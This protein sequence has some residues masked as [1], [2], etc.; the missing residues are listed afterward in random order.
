MRRGSAS[1]T[2]HVHPMGHILIIDDN[3]GV[4]DALCRLLRVH[5]YDVRAADSG[6]AGLVAMRAD[7]PALVLRDVSM[8]DMSGLDVLRA[9]RADPSLAGVTIVML[10]AGHDAGTQEAA[11]QLGARQ[12][13]DKGR[14]WPESLW[15]VVREFVTPP[16]SA[17][18]G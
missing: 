8:P 9:V 14:D 4:R 5:G 1:A 3:R 15:R 10:S 7:R 12:W 13:L 11:E 18:P 16:E 17:E 6:L 2:G